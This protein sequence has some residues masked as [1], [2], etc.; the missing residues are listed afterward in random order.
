VSGWGKQCGSEARK[1]ASALAALHGLT[2]D[3]IRSPKSG[4]RHAWPRQHIMHALISTGR[5]SYPAVGRLLN[6]DHSTV[7]HGVRAHERR[8]GA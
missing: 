6:R 7:H 4:P 8:A 1:L 2:L 3:D 5:Y